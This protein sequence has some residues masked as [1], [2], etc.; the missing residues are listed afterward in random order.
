MGPSEMAD[1]SLI[2]LSPLGSSTAIQHG[3]EIDEI[4]A[5]SHIEGVNSGDDPAPVTDIFYISTPGSSQRRKLL[6]LLRMED[7]FNDGHD[8]D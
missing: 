8:S 2:Q 6:N 4:Y 1:P 5:P 7:D 3:H